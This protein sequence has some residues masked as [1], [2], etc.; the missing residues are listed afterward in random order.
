MAE[1]PT[2]VVP[3]PRCGQMGSGNFCDRCGADMHSSAE[4]DNDPFVSFASGFFELKNYQ[5]YLQLYRR[6]LLHPVDNTIKAYNVISFDNAGKFL[7]LSVAFYTLVTASKSLYTAIAR[8]IDTQHFVWEEIFAEVFYLIAIIA[9]YLILMKFFYLF[10]SRKFGKK[11]KHDFVKMYCLFAGFLLPLT[12]LL[13]LLIGNPLMA[14]ATGMSGSPSAF[15]VI[16]G[17]I[18]NTV[19]LLYA[20]YIWEYFWKGPG[21]KVVSMLLWA[22]LISFLICYIVTL[23]V[24][25]RL[26]IKTF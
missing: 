25:D 17:I 1:N 10:A 5:R 7:K 21:F 9:G 20:Y 6:L 8:A 2:I 16:L 19:V 13:Y 24:Y 26:G 3:C 4:K 22:A 15:K 11:D 23:I 14:P 12:G 18:F